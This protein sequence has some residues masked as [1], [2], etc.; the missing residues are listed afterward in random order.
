LE[1]PPVSSLYSEGVDVEIHP[2]R[3]MTTG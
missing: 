3:P 2:L 1:G